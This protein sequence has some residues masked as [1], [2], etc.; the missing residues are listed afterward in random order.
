MESDITSPATFLA[1]KIFNR[2]PSQTL[3]R[4]Y[5]CSLT[6]GTRPLCDSGIRTSSR[7]HVDAVYPVLVGST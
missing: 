4:R 5:D 3:R 7:V 2:N 6:S 1:I